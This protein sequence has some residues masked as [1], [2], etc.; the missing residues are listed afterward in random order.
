MRGKHRSYITEHYVEGHRFSLDEDEVIRLR[1]TVYWEEEMMNRYSK[2]R[3]VETHRVGEVFTI[4]IGSN[5]STGSR[6]RLEPGQGLV[7]VDHEFISSCEKPGC[8][9]HYMYW[10]KGLNEGQK[11]LVIKKGRPG[12][13]STETQHFDI[14]REKERSNDTE[15]HRLGEVFTIQLYNNFTTG[16]SIE[17]EPSNGLVVLDKDFE[18]SS[19]NVG[20]GGYVTYRLKGTSRGVKELRIRQGQMWNPE[21]VGT[22]I[23]YFEIV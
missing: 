17:L 16:S 5:P 6:V 8:G 22:D 20:S 13:M 19:Q 2:E 12:S 3:N 23:K 4:K 21:T 15:V 18:L 14:V 10:L 7:V 11:T 1:Y 9:G